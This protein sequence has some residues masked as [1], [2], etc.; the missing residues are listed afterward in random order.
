VIRTC[1]SFL[2]VMK[3]AQGL[4]PQE[5]CEFGC[6]RIIEVNGG[7]VNFNVRFIAVNKQGEVGCAQLRDSKGRTMVSYINAS[8]FKALKGVGGLGG[9]I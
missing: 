1:G 6:K 4:S 2:V 5:A 8:G 7:T 9:K 3:M